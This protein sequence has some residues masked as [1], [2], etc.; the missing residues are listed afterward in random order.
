MTGGH[1]K[2]AVPFGGTLGDEFKRVWEAIRANQLVPTA[3]QRVSRTT[4]G[5]MVRNP[6][7]VSRDTK[8]DQFYIDRTASMVRVVYAGGSINDEPTWGSGSEK[9][10]LNPNFQCRAEVLDTGATFGSYEKITVGA[11]DHWIGKSS[12]AA[13]GA[14]FPGA[15]IG[16]AAHFNQI[17]I[18][19]PP[20]ATAG[21]GQQQIDY[22]L[23]AKPAAGLAAFDSVPQNLTQL[24]FPDP[25]ETAHSFSYAGAKYSVGEMLLVMQGSIVSPVQS[26]W[27]STHRNI[28]TYFDTLKT[29]ALDLNL[30]G[31]AWS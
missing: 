22:F 25:T 10:L 21:A 26:Q 14:I 17:I 7:E 18:S 27:D 28:G 31:R 30:K 8:T 19:A 5:T 2:N 11:A 15:A 12:W 13:A 20:K 24:W 6:Q 29:V 16:S 23:E 1:E 9:T 4:G 3:G